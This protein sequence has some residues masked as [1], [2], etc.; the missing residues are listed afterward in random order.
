VLAKTFGSLASGNAKIQDG[1]MG[2]A[3]YTHTKALCF[4]DARQASIQ[5]GSFSIF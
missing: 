3:N 1:K 4:T 5:I 2:A